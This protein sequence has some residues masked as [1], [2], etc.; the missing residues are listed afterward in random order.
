MPLP[1]PHRATFLASTLTVP[2][3]QSATT[4]FYARLLQIIVFDH[5]LRHPMVTL[6]DDDE[7]LA[8]DT[9]RALDVNHPQIEDTVD[10]M[11]RIARRHEVLWFELSLDRMRPQAALLR[12][13]LPTGSIDEWTSSADLPLSQQLGQCVAQWLSA[14][15]LPGVP[16]LPAF[17]IDD[18]RDAG[19]RLA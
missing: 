2:L 13:R 16:Q 9:G 10:W 18:V 3:E 11:F 4:G 14:R 6:G 19:A 7:R 12:S 17:T 15:R 1:Y 5:F 8:D